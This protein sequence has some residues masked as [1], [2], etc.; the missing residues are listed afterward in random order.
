[1]SAATKVPLVPFASDPIS[2]AVGPEPV[3]PLIELVAFWTPS[4]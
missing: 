3:A 4:I 1:M 2:N